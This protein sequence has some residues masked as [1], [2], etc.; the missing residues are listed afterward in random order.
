MLKVSFDGFVKDNTAGA[1]YVLRDDHGHLG[2]IK[3]LLCSIPFPKL[4][5]LPLNFG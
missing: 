3:L 4:V 2:E 1:N 5:L